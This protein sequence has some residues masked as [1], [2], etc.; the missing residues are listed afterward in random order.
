M[1][2]GSR[3][4]AGTTLYASPERAPL[5]R[6]VTELGTAEVASLRRSIVLMHGREIASTRRRSGYMGTGIISTCHV[7]N[8][9]HMQIAKGCTGAHQQATV[10]SSIYPPVLP[11]HFAFWKGIPNTAIQIQGEKIDSIYLSQNN[12]CRPIEP[13][14]WRQKL[15]L[16]PSPA[17]LRLIIIFEQQV[18]TG[19]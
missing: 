1:L 16:G 17:W 6:C 4:S 7:F 5:F 19:L 12:Q 9:H 18:Q 14:L 10:L 8:L 15:V 3:V 13:V 2:R 11:S